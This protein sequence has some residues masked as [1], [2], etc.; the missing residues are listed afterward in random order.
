LYDAMGAALRSV[1]PEDILGGHSS[2]IST[3][4]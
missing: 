3:A 1:G 4:S 2:P